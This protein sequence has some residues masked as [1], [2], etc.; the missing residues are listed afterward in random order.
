MAKTV[1][2]K[3]IVLSMDIAG[4]FYPVFCGKTMD[5]TTEQE[6]IETTHVNSSSDREYVAGMS[7][8][9]CTITGITTID[10]TNG[11]VGILYLK[12]QAVR[13]VVQ[14]FRIRFTADDATVKD[15]TFDGLIRTTGVSRDITG[16][17]NSNLV[18]RVTGAINYGDPI[19]PP[20]PPDCEVEDAIYLYESDG[21]ITAGQ[22]TAHSDLLEQ[23]G[24]EILMV[25]RTTDVQTYTSGTPTD[26]QF[27]TDLANGDIIFSS[28]LPFNEDEWVY[29]LYKIS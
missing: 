28:L 9:L 12:Q 22:N 23:A 2:G 26:S 18:I 8:S 20:T 25:V 14:S 4:T 15:A 3:N 1:K 7:S 21:G 13:R 29:I 6:E 19:A 11:R 10:N 5:L 17:S 16:Y 27:T 24:V